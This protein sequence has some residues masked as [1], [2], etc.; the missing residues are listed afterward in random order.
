MKRYGIL[1]IATFA[2]ALNVNAQGFGGS[3]AFDG[4]DILVSESNNSVFAGDLY[5]FNKVDGAWTTKTRLMAPDGGTDGDGFGASFA[6]H[7]PHLLV[8]S[9]G[10]NDGRGAVYEYTRDGESWKPS[11]ELALP[12]MQAEGAGRKV[13]VSGNNAF[14]A[15]AGAV[16]VFGYSDTG[17]NHVGHLT[18]ADS[19]MTPGF[20]GNVAASGSFAFV[21]GG[22]SRGRRG[23]GAGMVGVYHKADDGTWS[24]HSTLSNDNFGPRGSFGSTIYADGR[25]VM[26]GATGANNGAGAV[27][28]Y[29]FNEEGNSWNEIGMLFPAVAAPRDG[30]GASIARV[31]NEIWIGAPGRLGRTGAIFAYEIDDETGAWNGGH[32]VTGTDLP[33]G[34]S[35]GGGIETAENAAVVFASGYDNR[36]GAAIVMEKD[37]NGMWNQTGVLVNDAKGYASITG[38]TTQCSDDIAAAFPCKDVDMVS[39]LSVKDIGGGRGMRTNDIWGWEDPTNG[40]EYALIGMT[41]AT[42]FVD[43]TDAHNPVYLGE[44][45]LTEGARPS[46]WRDIKVYKDHAFIVSDGAGNHGM[47]IFDLTQLRDVKNGPVTFEATAHYDQIASAHNI[48]I[49]EETGY[50]Y[51]VGSSSGGTTCGGGLHMINIQDPVNPTFAG[52]FQDN[53]TGRRLTGYSHDAQCVNYVGPDVDHKGKEICFGSNETAISIAD[54]SDKDNPIALSS[55]SYPNVAY[56]HQGWLTEDQRFFY[57]N[58]EG[59]EPQGLVEGT[60][61]LIWDVADLDDPILVGE[62]IA[63]V[64]STDHNLYIKGNLMYQSNYD[65][66]LRILDISDPST[67][68][69]VG[70]FDT[71]PYGEDGTVGGGSWSNY[72]YFK[73][74]N[75]V[76]TSGREGLFILKKKGIDS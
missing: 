41:D 57:V 30:F 7:G 42:S 17:W 26:I 19:A 43:V 28:I 71:V 50:A 45:N 52:C 2:L 32:P 29:T 49:N 3:V 61:T 39:F 76:V 34:A 56:T 48:V 14:V 22:M 12:A 11:G 66:G 25:D 62:H 33:R 1:L 36:E 54:V 44:L 6:L 55:A 35:F 10:A 31:G 47:Q 73:S 69:E 18:P 68:V 72:P 24:H 60:R 27:N 51:S 37:A 8:G 9:P 20:G 15:E 63:A 21:S 53:K 38:E 46:V 75:I 5:V 16:H 23:G 40:R 67:P 58:D 74:G 64:K 65:S 13:T 70:F 4:G 59:D